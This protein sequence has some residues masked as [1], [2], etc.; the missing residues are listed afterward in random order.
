MN[1]LL[2]KIIKI[3]G[4]IGAAFI[5]LIMI[6]SSGDVLARYGLGAPIK[7]AYEINE[8]MFLSAV[9]LGLA[10][11]QLYKGH[12][13]VELFV[14]RLP[15]KAAIILETILI[16][17]ALI[18]YGLIGWEG[19]MALID[20]IKAGEYR[21]GLIPIPLW[22]AR[23]MVPLGTGILC[24]KFM[25]EVHSNIKKLVGTNLEGK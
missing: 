17:I 24:L 13:R 3:S 10:Y 18:I 12:V 11:T 23:L 14:S 4:G 21:W 2:I 5:L 22:P 15:A 19:L 20:S 25:S 7:G 9:F 6:L 8:I 1:A 16:C